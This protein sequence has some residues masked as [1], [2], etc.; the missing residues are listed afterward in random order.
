LTGEENRLMSPISEA[1][2]KPV[3]QPIPG[4]LSNNEI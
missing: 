1:I 4:A 3:T 2:V